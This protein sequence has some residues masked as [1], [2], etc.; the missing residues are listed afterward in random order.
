MTTSS[1]STAS[2]SRMY[3]SVACEPNNAHVTTDAP[4]H[5]SGKRQ[6]ESGSPA[7]D[8]ATTDG[9]ALVI[10]M[11][12]RRRW[13]SWSRSR[14]RLSAVGAL[15]MARRRR[16]QRLFGTVMAMEMALMAGD[17]CC[18]RGLPLLILGAVDC[19]GGGREGRGSVGLALVGGDEKLAIVA[20]LMSP[21][22]FFRLHHRPSDHSLMLSPRLFISLSGLSLSRMLNVF[23]ASFPSPLTHFQTYCL[24]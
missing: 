8:V 5:P 21:Y 19:V 10:R 2:Q 12:V 22:F 17:A 18:A 13:T 23:F 20:S 9:R 7:V 4:S 11:A 6:R 15:R 1:E 24:T 14:A 3:S 16:H